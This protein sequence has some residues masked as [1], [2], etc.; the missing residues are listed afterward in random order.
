MKYY[1]KL[2]KKYFKG[3]VMV[4]FWWRYK[5]SMMIKYIDLILRAHCTSQNEITLGNR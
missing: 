5:N 3:R 1:T 4:K 2:H